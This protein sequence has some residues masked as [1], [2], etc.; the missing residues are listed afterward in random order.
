MFIFS[1]NLV[2]AKKIILIALIVALVLVGIFIPK[3]LVS[4]TG[5]NQPGTTQEHEKEP[6]S[7][8]KYFYPISDYNNRIKYRW[9]SKQVNANDAVPYC[10]A[11]F[12]GLHNA[13]DLEA[14]EAEQNPEVPVYSISDATVN[15]IST[16]S[17][18]GGLIVLSANIE[19]QL[20]MV[21]Y[22]HV[23]LSSSPLAVGQS[24]KAGDFIANLGKGCTQEA[25]GERK[26][27]HFSIRK[28]TAVDVR[29]Y[30]G[31]VQEV[32]NWVNPKEFL[33]QIKASTK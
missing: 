23:N 12:A 2:M 25:G 32:Q 11:Q 9:Y 13:D 15:S 22:G 16:V 33:E 24:V 17:G 30:V 18:Y 4:P 6:K 20:Y 29:G 5:S 28:G 7:E 27:L 31:S 19:N 3:K 14:T 8:S 26:H 21:Y 1:F 10:G